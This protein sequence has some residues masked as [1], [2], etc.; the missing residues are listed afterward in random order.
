ML[1]SEMSLDTRL[2]PEQCAKIKDHFQ[3]RKPLLFYG[4]V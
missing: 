2:T 1:Y 4:E 3:Y